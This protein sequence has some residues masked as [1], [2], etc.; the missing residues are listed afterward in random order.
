MSQPVS[1]KTSRE[2]VEQAAAPVSLNAR[3]MAKVLES[4]ARSIDFREREF[5]EICV[6]SGLASALRKATTLL[7]A[8]SHE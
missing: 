3:G 2:V 5:G 8:C 6:D 7:R 4:Y 1:D